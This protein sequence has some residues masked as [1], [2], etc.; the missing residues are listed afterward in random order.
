MIQLSDGS[1]AHKRGTTNSRNL[2]YINPSTA[3]WEIGYDSEVIY[4][5]VTY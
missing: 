3:V 1:W 2:G 4:F 5:A